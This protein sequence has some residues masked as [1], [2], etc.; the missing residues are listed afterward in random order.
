MKGRIALAWGGGGGGSAC[1]RSHLDHATTPSFPV[2]KCACWKSSS[3]T[4]E[5][6]LPEIQRFSFCERYSIELYQ[7]NAGGISWSPSEHFGY[8]TPLIKLPQGLLSGINILQGSLREGERL[9]RATMKSGEVKGKP[10]ACLSL[11]CQ[12]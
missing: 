9:R 11:T 8:K 1:D 4:P 12:H 2:S 5:K 6:H 3:A 7:T 10:R